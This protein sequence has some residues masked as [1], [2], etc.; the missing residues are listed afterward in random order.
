ML[1]LEI[2]KGQL[3]QPALLCHVHRSGRAED[4]AALGGANL[5][6]DDARAVEGDE[7]Q[8][9]ERAAEVAFEDAVAKL[10]EMAAGCALGARPEP[11]AQPG[12]R[13]ER[14]HGEARLRVS[15]PARPPANPQ[16]GALGHHAVGGVALA[17]RSRRRVALP[18]RSRR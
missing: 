6:E 12:D 5:D 13:R 17:L 8:L 18:T 2:E 11:A 7:I 14:K 10:F 9:A 1:L 3:R 4:V 15:G 16:A